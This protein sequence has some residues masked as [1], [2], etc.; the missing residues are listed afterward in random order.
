MTRSSGE[1]E[2]AESAAGESRRTS[3]A[4]DRIASSSVDCNSQSSGS[5]KPSLLTSLSSWSRSVSPTTEN[6]SSNDVRAVA[7]V[8]AA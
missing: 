7:F 2:S 6:E 8:R 3:T 1:R 4:L 5:L